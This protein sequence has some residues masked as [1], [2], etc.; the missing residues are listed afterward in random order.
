[1]NQTNEPSELETKLSSNAIDAVIKVFDLGMSPQ[2]LQEFKEQAIK[3]AKA[4]ANEW[5]LERSEFDDNNQP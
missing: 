4:I 2:Q 1:M 5:E 3:D